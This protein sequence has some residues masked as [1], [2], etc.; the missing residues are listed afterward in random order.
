M[1]GT[2]ISKTFWGL[3]PNLQMNDES[4]EELADLEADSLFLTQGQHESL[5]STLPILFLETLLESEDGCI[6]NYPDPAIRPDWLQNMKNMQ[7]MQNAKYAHI[8][9]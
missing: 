2:T 1:T 8:M 3:Q 7:N 5:W 4:E 6:Q 9:S